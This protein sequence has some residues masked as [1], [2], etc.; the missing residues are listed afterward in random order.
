MSLLICTGLVNSSWEQ[1]SQQLLASGIS[2]INDNNEVEGLV[3][4]LN[5]TQTTKRVVSLLRKI[6][7]LCVQNDYLLSLPLEVIN[8]DLVY[9]MSSTDKFDIKWLLF[10]CRPTQSLASQP[11]ESI[12]PNELQLHFAEWHEQV[13]KLNN[14]SCQTPQSTRLLNI[15]E[16][17]TQP[18]AF[19]ENAA[20]F[21]NKPLDVE[22]I[23][24]LTFNQ[25]LLEQLTAH[26]CEIAFP[27]SEQFEQLEELYD[28]IK[29]RTHFNKSLSEFNIIEQT[30]LSNALVEIQ[31]NVNSIVK[32]DENL[33][34]VL[35][36]KK[37][38]V[39][40][41]H[42]KLIAVERELN[43]TKLA[44][45]KLEQ[46]TQ[47]YQ[48]IISEKNNKLDELTS[49]KELFGLHAN[50]LQEE[51]ETTHASNVSVNKQLE[52]LTE[53]LAV[54]QNE[55][56][57]EREH[58]VKIKAEYVDSAAK[59]EQII[60]E[61]EI[62][63][64]SLHSVNEQN[65][66]L[67]TE[68]LEKQ[69]QINNS[70]Q[71]VEKTLGENNIALLQISQLQD[72]L[73]ITISEKQE[74]VEKVASQS[75]QLK[76]ASQ[77]ELNITDENE[78]ALLQINQ[79][80]EELEI[81]FTEKQAL[82]NQVL[83]LGEQL[84]SALEV[85]ANTL[86][87]N[88][89]ALLQINQLQEELEFY[90]QK[91]IEQEKLMS[92]SISNN[93]AKNEKIFNC[94]SIN[95]IELLGQY[96][97]EG[98]HELKIQLNNVALADGRFFESLRCKLVD[99][100][101]CLGIEFRPNDELVDYLQWYEKYNDEY[102]SY[103]VY[104]PQPSAELKDE[105]EFLF[106]RLNTSDRIL[107]NSIAKNLASYLAT[108]DAIINLAELS[109]TSLRQWRVNAYQLASQISN[110]QDWMSFDSVM[111]KEEMRTEGYE[112]LWLTFD[113]LL[114]GERYFEQFNIKASVTDITDDAVFAN[115]FMIELRELPNGMAPLQAWPPE[116]SDEFGYK[117][118][119]I[120]NTQSDVLEIQGLESLSVADKLLVGHFINNFAGFVN[121]LHEQ[122]VEFDR[123][124]QQWEGIGNRLYS[125][126]HQ[127]TQ[128]AEM[129]EHPD[130]QLDES[131][132][133]DDAVQNGEP[134]IVEQSED[135]Q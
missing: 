30:T 17:A 135:K 70:T 21:L 40:R 41:L 52:Q 99:K 69:Q 54:S 88:E 114:I 6:A 63:Q 95:T 100:S 13:T 7:S 87:E 19:V 65:E 51:L 98:Y 12:T 11:I 85:K 86:S 113:N 134:T 55:L 50:Q 66:I 23:N 61:R 24:G 1:L 48:D 77:L 27:E 15:V 14:I 122:Q 2:N 130:V 57:F 124:W 105:Q 22:N 53:S 126:K 131:E 110:V 84:Q 3:S 75:N 129:Q 115:Q 59:Y 36:E 102:G 91:F 83:D 29:L 127:L 56:I 32:Q 18:Q 106:E 123:P 62:L 128:G 60:A 117:L 8:C 71:L 39:E 5:T 26:Y 47:K 118:N 96:D 89:I 93:V 132:F 44:N 76:N 112:H 58:K 133:A 103:V 104:L 81:I 68:I 109:A 38:E 4:Q 28:D 101:G 20:E 116:T 92:N 16:C 35:Q 31:K 37:I 45:E 64:G 125:L 42:S 9:T 94:I 67:Q 108:D 33:T 74:L 121:K 46:T 72:E 78:I 73:E 107:I 79:L 49:E 34:L 120:I 90:F 82:A 80:Q 119:L 10:Y 111:L 97:T 43:N 25:S